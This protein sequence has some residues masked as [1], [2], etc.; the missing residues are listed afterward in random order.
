MSKPKAKTQKLKEKVSKTISRPKVLIANRGAIARRI[1]RACN[2]LGLETV[3]VYS[4]AD[5]GAPHLAEAS[6][7]YPLAGHRAVDTYL[8]QSRLLEIM[9]DV[10]AGA[11]HP[12]YGF[13]A[14]NADFAH[15]VVDR[16]YTFIGPDPQW[17]AK[18]GDKVAA[19]KLMAGQGFPTFAG[20]ELIDDAESALAEAERIGYPVLVKPTGGGGGMGM[21]K[22]QDKDAL[23]NA[24]Q[25]ARA[26]AEAAFSSGGVY[27]EKLIANPRHIE[28]QILADGK[29]GA[30][31]VFERDCSVQR[32]NQK[33]IEE[34]PAP[35]IPESEILKVAQSAEEVCR[36]LRY[37][38][39][40]TLETLRDESGSYGFLEM[41]TRIQVEHGVT[42]EVTGLDLVALQI[43]LALGGTLPD[44]VARDGYAIE[45][46]IYAEDSETLLPST[47]KLSVFRPPNMQGVRVETG[48][49]E[50]QLVTP[51]YDAMLAKVIAKAHTRELAI[52][53]LLVALRDFEIRGVA[54]NQKLLERVLL[55]GRFVDGKIDTGFLERL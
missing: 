17:L 26:I 7:T 8:N 50:G 42:E 3:A 5:V 13:L 30:L 25:R 33:L 38:N 54:T 18:M 34:S 48:Y 31:H 15:A 35:G 9:H 39:V 41:N 40:G 45:A 29:G 55:D 28:F 37:N 27:L 46:R 49:Q 16:G 12:G 24:I 21:E 19:R 10:D 51:Y 20:S 6:E 14:E 43:E 52:G 36:E 53:R 47:G 2:A 22:V 44:Q 23:V 4:E 11:V 32:R 1:V